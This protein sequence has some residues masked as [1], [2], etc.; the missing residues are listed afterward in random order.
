M[1]DR[2]TMDRPTS[3]ERRKAIQD[4]R[5]HLR[6]RC[7]ESLDHWLASVAKRNGVSG[8]IV[9]DVEGGLIASANELDEGR[10]LAAMT[11][12]AV[13]SDEPVVL[14]FDAGKLVV[15]T[16]LWEGSRLL[17]GAIGEEAKS[18]SAVEEASARIGSILP[19]K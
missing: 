4:R 8:L 16:F 12:Q 9:S 18:R 14:D 3:E 19:G 10:E 5:K 6:I 13:P 11:G 15:R 7:D 2:R 17:I 1:N